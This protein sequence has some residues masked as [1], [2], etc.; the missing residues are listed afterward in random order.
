MHL[1]FFLNYRPIIA[2]YLSNIIDREGG[3]LFLISIQ[4]GSEKYILLG[5]LSTH[6][7]GQAKVEKSIF[8]RK[9]SRVR[10]WFRTDIIRI[11]LNDFYSG[12]HS[13]IKISVKFIWVENLKVPR[14]QPK[15]NLWPVKTKF[16]TFYARHTLCFSHSMTRAVRAY[17]SIGA[18]YQP[19]LGLN[20]P[21]CSTG[22][23]TIHWL[24]N[25]LDAGLL[26]NMMKYE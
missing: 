11:I 9:N 10:R 22:S 6:G 5:W 3:D 14:I 15:F 23:S 21:S 26:I 2:R 20:V 13:A 12:F 25:E 8:N 19:W 18:D 4:V 7:F 24:R 17:I 16:K 1:L